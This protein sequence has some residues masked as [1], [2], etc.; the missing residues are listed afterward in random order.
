VPGPFAG[1]VKLEDAREWQLVYLDVTA[2][3]ILVRLADLREQHVA[4]AG[5]EMANV[6]APSFPAAMEDTLRGD[7]LFRRC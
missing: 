5:L 6:I 3:P 4:V 7:G 1:S 2:R